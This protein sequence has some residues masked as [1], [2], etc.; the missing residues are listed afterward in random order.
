MLSQK[1]ISLSQLI[2]P[3]LIQYNENEKKNESLSSDKKLSVKPVIRPQPLNL[4]LINGINGKSI[5][6]KGDLL[7]K[8][9]NLYENQYNHELYTHENYIHK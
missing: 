3:K 2:T 8:E 6:K 9:L 7:Y 1:N 5:N 4:K